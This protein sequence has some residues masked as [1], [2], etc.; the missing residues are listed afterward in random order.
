MK[1]EG[2]IDLGQGNVSVSESKLRRSTR[3]LKRGKSKEK[4][5]PKLKK[6]DLNKGLMPTCLTLPKEARWEVS[7]QY[8]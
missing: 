8:L 4:N 7:R 2:F 3:I 1:V 5:Q 6:R